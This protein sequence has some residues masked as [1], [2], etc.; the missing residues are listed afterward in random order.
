M[1]EFEFALVFFERGYAIRTDVSGFRDGIAKSKSAVMDSIMGVKPFQPNP[2]FPGSRP[3]KPLIQLKEITPLE[4]EDQ[5]EQDI[6]TL[7]PENVLPLTL[8][9]DQKGAYLGELALDYDYLIE[10]RQEI[11][12]G[13]DDETGHDE[14]QKILEL[15]CHAIIYLN[16]RAQFWCQQESVHPKKEEGRS[17]SPTPMTEGVNRELPSARKHSLKVMKVPSSGSRPTSAR[18]PVSGS[19]QQPHYELTKIQLYETKYRSKNSEKKCKYTDGYFFSIRLSELFI[20]TQELFV[21]VHCPQGGWEKGIKNLHSLT[22]FLP[23]LSG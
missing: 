7:L 19:D 12:A 3:R 5:E 15:A 1:G 10:L 13:S 18:R 17:P 16:H 11:L 20:T 8:T 23:L 21:E 22:S 14:G 6:V 4:S 2:N 9:V